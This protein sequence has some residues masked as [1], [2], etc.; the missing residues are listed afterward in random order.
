[1][2]IYKVEKH[3]RNGCVTHYLIV[4]E[5]DYDDESVKCL[6]EDWCESDSAGHNYGWTVEWNEVKDVHIILDVLKKEIEKTEN[7]VKSLNNYKSG[8]EG[9]MLELLGYEEPR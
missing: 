4:Q 6:V 5:D 8:L 3:Y 1:M 9:K 7:Q 2:R